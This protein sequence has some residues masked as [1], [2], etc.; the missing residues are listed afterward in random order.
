MKLKNINQIANELD[1]PLSWIKE[2]V[3]AGKIP[4]L[5]IGRKYKF[6]LEAVK[7]SLAETVAK[8]K[9]VKPKQAESAMLTS[10]QVRAKLNVGKT[11]FY[12]MLSDGRIGV[13]PLR[14]G[15]K[16][17]FPAAELERWFE[18]S[19]EAGGFIPADRWRQY[20]SRGGK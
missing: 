3:E 8:R 2:Q 6:E 4:C 20:K 19:I 5:R 12:E 9:E 17:L 18:A 15:R 7:A 14:A 16:L 10:G 13:R 1:L 11:L